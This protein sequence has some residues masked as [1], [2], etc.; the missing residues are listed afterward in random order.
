MVPLRYRNLANE[1]KNRLMGTFSLF[2]S[3]CMLILAGCSQQGSDHKN[4]SEQTP[5]P[6]K[7]NIIVIMTDQ[8]RHH[9]HWPQG[10]AEKHLPTLQRLKKHGL[11][12]NRAYTAACECTPSR[13]VLT[14]GEYFPVNQV[15]VTP[16]KNGL[17]PGNELMDISWLLR[18]HGGYDVVWKGKWHLSPPLKGGHNWQEDDIANVQTKYAIYQWNPP[19]AGTAITAQVKEPNGNVFDGLSTLGGGFAAN[20][21][22]FLHGNDKK[23]PKAVQGFGEGA[24]EYIKS[25]AATPKDQRKPF[26]LFISLVNPHDVWVYPANWKEAGYDIDVFS[27]MGIELPVNYADDL[28]TKPSIQKKARDAFNKISPLNGS[29]EEKNYINFYAYLNTLSDTHVGEILDALDAAGLTD[30]TIIIRTADHGELG[31]SHGM[32]EKAYTVYEEMTH[33]PFIIHN[34]KLFPEAATTDAFYCHLDLMPT[35]AE[36]AGVPHF[37][38]YGKGVSIVPVIDDPESYVQDAVLFAY[39]DIFFLPKD[40]PGSHIRALREGHWTYAMYYSEGG[41][42]IEY[43]MYNLKTDPGQLHNLLYGDVTPLHAKEAR[44]LHVKLEEKVR[45]ANALPKD[46]PWPAAEY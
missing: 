41:K 34:P 45:H 31:L 28:S 21:R 27:K 23:D 1:V 4:T 38:K 2:S 20:D 5:L 12:F 39:D 19:D 11:S 46:F 14:S 15:P 43:E 13:A 9:V 22:R 42:D 29:E 33:I 37:E 10:W 16:P 32:R 44:R 40:A 3:L 35:I 30:D 18:E 24:L 8:E 36:L 26:C 25:I 6:D 17:P 7:P